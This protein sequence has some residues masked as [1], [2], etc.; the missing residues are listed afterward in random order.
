MLAE[1]EHPEWRQREVMRGWSAEDQVLLNVAFTLLNSLQ[2]EG[3][4]TEK[5]EQVL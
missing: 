1:T 2:I 3:T 5:V 4:D